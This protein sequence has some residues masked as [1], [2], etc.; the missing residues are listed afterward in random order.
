MCRTAGRTPP[1]QALWPPACCVNSRRGAGTIP[2][3]ATVHRR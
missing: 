2:L 1:R 3:A